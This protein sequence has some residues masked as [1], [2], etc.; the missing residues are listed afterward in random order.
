MQY[1]ALLS[2]PRRSIAAFLLLTVVSWSLGLPTFINKARAASLDNVSDLLSDSGLL[3]PSDHTITFTT[4]Q[5]ILGGETVTVTFPAGFDTATIA[6][7]DVDVTNGGAEVT[8]VDGLA[9]GD[10]EWGFEMAADVLT[11]ELGALE[12]VPA[13]TIVVIEIGNHATAGGAGADNQITNPAANGSNV[14]AIAT[15]NA[16]TDSADTRVYIVEHVLVTAEVET[17]FDFEVN[18][19]TTGAGNSVNGETITL[20][21]TPTTLAFGVLT[22]DSAEVMAQELRVKT[23]A[24]YGFVVTAQ[25]DTHLVSATGADINPFKDD[26][27][28]AVP[29]AWTQPLATIDTDTTYGHEGITS[30]DAN[31]NANEF[32]DQLFAGDF[33]DAPR[34]VFSHTGPVTYSGVYGDPEYAA[35]IATTRVGYKVEI[36]ALQ[37]AADDYT[38][39]IR[40]VATPTF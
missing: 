30:E 29:A 24:N 33:V 25:A 10:N 26:S 16:T 12:T 4:D 1:T 39:T 19:L 2:T 38:Q 5:A 32:G 22:P 23:N 20:T 6:V 17:I 35:N 37:E 34:Q 15:T 7:T 27:N 31:L 14:I 18:A 8:M 9:P 28:L 3:A 11:L 13:A 36:S 21:S 40:Y